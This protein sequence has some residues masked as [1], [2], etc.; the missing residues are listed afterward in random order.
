[1]QKINQALIV[2][3]A[4]LVAGCAAFFSV[5]GL[6]LLF[7]SF[8][9]MFMAGSLEYAKLVTAAYV[10]S[11][12][13]ELGK[14]LRIYLA[15]AV[16]V[17][18]VITS[19]GIF[20]FL[21]DAFQSQSLRIEQVDREVE[22]INNKIDINKA[23]ITRYQQQVNNMTQIRNSQEQNLSKLIDGEKSTGRV[24]N[25]IKT[26]DIQIT[27][28]SQKIDSLN[29]LNV[30]LLQNIDSVKNKNLDL[31]REIGGFR[32]IAETFNIPLKQAV[33]WFILMIV[34]VFDPLAIALVLAYNTK[35][36]YVHDVQNVYVNDVQNVQ[37]V[38]EEE[39]PKRGRPKKIEMD[40]DWIL[41]MKSVEGEKKYAQNGEEAKIEY[42]LN[43]IGNSKYIVDLGAKD[44]YSL[45][46]TR[47]F[48]ENGYQCLFIDSESEAG[49]S[50]EVKKHKL[51]SGN[52]I[53]LLKT[54]KCPKV[55]D[56][57]DIDLDGTD[58]WILR[59]VLENYSPLLILAEFNASIPVGKS[60]TIPNESE[61][62]WSG[63]NFF[64]FSFS[65]AQKIAEEFGYT[66]VHQENNMNLF[67][68]KN[69]YLVN[70]EIPEVKYEEVHYFVE[71]GRND[72]VEV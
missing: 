33:K 61:F 71:N 67:M 30:T 9:V 7:R 42:I 60:L 49:E 12:W 39:K 43:N 38:D 17:L 13:T 22:L 25:M 4:L 5:T 53:P 70:V 62:V 34:F 52:V 15:F 56:M 1:M 21:S 57:L 2:I 31:E 23:E 24:S 51:F 44:G 14:A 18:M 59:K 16:I 54:Y 48:V 19:M 6:G 27:T 65:A 8:S 68:V 66:I 63:D 55:F 26:A 3:A 46:N 41:K 29:T 37:N 58:Y 40:K 20:G 64:G 11:R 69:E 32:F 10:K 36:T 35:K 45:S 50:T 28:N 72:W 47:Y